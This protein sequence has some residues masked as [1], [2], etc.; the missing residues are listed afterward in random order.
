V[1]EV[2]TDQ[3]TPSSSSTSVS[4]ITQAVEGIEKVVLGRASASIILVFNGT[5]TANR[6]PLIDF[7]FPAF[8]QVVS[9]L[10]AP[11]GVL[12]VLE[13]RTVLPALAP[14]GT[15]PRGHRASIR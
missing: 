6:E 10:E 3:A 15:I 9:G 4:H 8:M 7:R 11:G 5:G 1:G 13:G 2:V 14:G 12:K